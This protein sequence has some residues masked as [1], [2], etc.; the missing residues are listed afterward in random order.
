[1]ALDARSLLQP[2]S[3]FQ[4]KSKQHLVHI[5][6]YNDVQLHA[7]SHC[8]CSSPRPPGVSRCWRLPPL[9]S[10]HS[11]WLLI[12]RR[13]LPNF[14][15][16]PTTLTDSHLHSSI[17]ET[18]RFCHCN[19]SDCVTC[20]QPDHPYWQALEPPTTKL[21]AHRNNIPNP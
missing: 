17:A 20:H 2:P 5:Y 8:L 15:H 12:P 9:S 19:R 1:M 18:L 13:L 10:P 11:L 3:G 14:N 7:C 21:R 6:V 16:E 4:C